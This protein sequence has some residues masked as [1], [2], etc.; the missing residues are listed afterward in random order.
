MDNIQTKST[1][2][3]VIAA[4]RWLL[5]EDDGHGP[6]QMAHPVMD[7]YG[8]TPPSADFDDRRTWAHAQI[9]NL[10]VQNEMLAWARM[11]LALLEAKHG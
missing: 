1:V 9:L 7:D 5:Y 6:Q 10:L 2:Q 8:V 11:Y 4:G 3:G